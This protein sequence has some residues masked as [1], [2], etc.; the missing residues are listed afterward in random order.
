MKTKNTL[1]N[2]Q[3]ILR[4][5]KNKTKRNHIKKKLRKYNNPAITHP[6]S[7]SSSYKVTKQS[8]YDPAIT[9]PASLQ[10]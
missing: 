6:A 10:S 4:K 8:L 7:L 1:K 9:H 5:Y 3:K 2:K